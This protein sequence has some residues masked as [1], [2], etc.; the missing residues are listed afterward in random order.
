MLVNS[1]FSCFTKNWSR[2]D[3]TGCLVKMSASLEICLAA[4]LHLVCDPSLHQSPLGFVGD[5]KT[6]ICKPTA[7]ESTVGAF[8]CPQ[9]LHDKQQCVN[10]AALELLAFMAFRGCPPSFQSWC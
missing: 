8:L 7:P 6:P 5:L 2:I 10:G 1:L 3:F 4:V 9:V